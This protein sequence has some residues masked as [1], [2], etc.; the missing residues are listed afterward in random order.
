VTKIKG[1]IIECRFEYENDYESY[2]S[3]PNGIS[4]LKEIIEFNTLDEFEK[5]EFALRNHGPKE[6]GWPKYKLLKVVDSTEESMK[7]IINKA[8]AKYEKQKK[9]DAARKKKAAANR[10]KKA[11][12]KKKKEMLKKAMESLSP[13]EIEKMLKDTPMAK[14]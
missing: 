5:V 6:D 14:G 9:T 4:S 7:D 12:E 10:K 2:Y 1:I 11:E 13:E 3:H 8:V